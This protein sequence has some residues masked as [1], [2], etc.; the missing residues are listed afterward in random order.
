MHID[1]TEIDNL[2]VGQ[3]T[4]LRKERYVGEARPADFL[5]GGNA[6][7]AGADMAVTW[8]GPAAPATGLCSDPY[9]EALQQATALAVTLK[10]AAMSHLAT[11]TSERAA[12]LAG[13]VA[14]V[15]RAVGLDDT[16]RDRVRDVLL[17]GRPG[18]YALRTFTVDVEAAAR[19]NYSR[20]IAYATIRITRT[21]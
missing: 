9:L 5:G 14:S 21:A 10:K 6:A 20:M 1:F 15:A 4:R 8:W 7:G 11:T 16:S 17:E 3:T 2:S 19:L 12:A 13:A 18:V